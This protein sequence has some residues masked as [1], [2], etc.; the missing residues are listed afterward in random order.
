[1]KFETARIHFLSDV[2]FV[3]VAVSVTN[4]PFARNGHM[5]Q[6]TPGLQTTQWGKKLKTKR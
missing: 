5:G 3:V 6:E 1:M 2:F 4:G